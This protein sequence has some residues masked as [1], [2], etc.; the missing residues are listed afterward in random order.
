MIKF[1][2]ALSVLIVIAMVL[3]LMPIFAIAADGDIIL[4]INK[5]DTFKGT[6]ATTAN[7]LVTAEGYPYSIVAEKTS[8]R[9]IGGGSEEFVVQGSTSATVA[10]PWTK[11][12][13]TYGQ[14]TI[15]TNDA[16]VIPAGNYAVSVDPKVLYA[17]GGLVY[18][19]VEGKYVGIYDAYENG[20]NAGTTNPIH[21]GYVSISGDEAADGVEIM[22]ASAAMGG[23]TRHWLSMSDTIFSPVAEIPAYST[24]EVNVLDEGATAF[25]EEL[26]LGVTATFNTKVKLSDGTYRHLNGYAV[27]RTA[28]S[29]NKITVVSSNP[30]V[31][32]VEQVNNFTDSAV[33]RTYGGEAVY[34]LVALADGDVT[35]TITA[36]IGGFA[37]TPIVKN[38]K[39]GAG[40]PEPV[41]EPVYLFFNDKNIIVESNTPANTATAK[42]GVGYSI[43]AN[44]TTSALAS[45]AGTYFIALGSATTG[46]TTTWLEYRAQG[47]TNNYGQV[48]ISAEGLKAAS[49]KVSVPDYYYANAGKVYDY[50][51]GKYVGMYTASKFTGTAAPDKATD[52][53]DLGYVTLSEADVASGTKILFCNAGRNPEVASS[54]GRQI[55]M[56]GLKFEK[57][58][59]V[60]ES[61]IDAKFYS[62]DEK[63]ALTPIEDLS[64]LKELKSGTRT[65]ISLNVNP[66]HVNNY[67]D[68]GNYDRNNSI[69]VTSSNTDVIL[70]TDI[71]VAE[72][73]TRMITWGDSTTYKLEAVGAGEATITATAYVDGKKIAEKSY[74]LV[75]TSAEPGVEAPSE[76]SFGVYQLGGTN[77]DITISGVEYT[78]GNIG[79]ARVGTTLTLKAA[80]ASA[81]GATFAYW[82]V[83]NRILSDNAETTY[84]INTNTAIIAVYDVSEENATEKKVEF[85]NAGGTLLDTLVANEDGY[86]DSTKIPTATFTGYQFSNWATMVDGEETVFD[87]SASLVKSVTRA[88]AKHNEIGV[89]VGDKNYG[90]KLTYSD[91][92]ATYWT[93]TIGG[94][95]KVVAYGTDYTYYVWDET[96]I[97]S[98]SDEVSAKP[99]VVLDDYAN[100]SY[101]IEYFVP[102]GYEKVE[103]GILYGLSGTTPTV[104]SAY[105]KAVSAR[106]DNHGCLT[107]APSG[108]SE[109]VVRG[110]LIYENDS[111]EK[112]VIYTD[113]KS[114][115]E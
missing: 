23:G 114:I 102:V 80:E 28:D 11:V 52:Y 69:I 43:I 59:A 31:L 109:A 8:S 87:A 103:V 49:Y 57:V 37:Q 89:A 38:I 90:D 34:K 100:G 46:A 62:V 60:P 81:T 17:N 94:E 70:P 58:D 39:V 12:T 2:R 113:V 3:S 74:D 14:V 111:G 110:Y 4:K 7:T 1:K 18:V 19:Y 107:A 76:A 66:V 64:V 45:G 50:V 79:S 95:E 104:S 83:G 33:M 9:G 91:A 54:R 25:P 48:A 88:V 71:K 55:A 16:T 20:A 10:T 35:V 93:R 24:V 47:D 5:S 82:K 56:T 92:D 78:A 53:I 73:N 67:D 42:A 65:D 75:V 32:S 115:G 112:R 13:G 15:K 99:V 44:E 27:D 51:G 26:A 108:S 98:Y 105:S 61:T 41:D 40:T 101:M 106:A 29:L 97:K 22:Y 86:I 72:S 6:T 21:I 77:A 36:T 63:T 85:W 96:E 68:K 30:D 84:T